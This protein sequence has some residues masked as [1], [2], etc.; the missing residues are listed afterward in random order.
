MAALRF[1]DKHGIQA[2]SMRK[3]AQSLNVEAMS[4]YNHVNNKEDLIDGIVELVIAEFQ[5]P[6]ELG[7]WKAQMRARAISAHTVLLKHPWAAPLM[8]SRIHIGPAMLTWTNA[9][10]GCLINA[11]FSYPMADH[12]WNALDNHL[13]GFTLQR[14]NSPVEPED[15]PSSAEHYLPMIPLEQ[16]PHVFAMATQIAEGSHSGINDFTFGLDLLLDGLERL[17]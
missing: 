15:Y 2:L 9:T 1:A 11:G 16:Y 14:L 3:L 4:L 8:L 12:A 13:Y 6:D 17:L 10:V 7:D 5:I